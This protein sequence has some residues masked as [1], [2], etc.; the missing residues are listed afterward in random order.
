MIRAIQAGHKSIYK[1]NVV[2]IH[3]ES[4]FRKGVHTEWQEE[5]FMRL[6]NKYKN[7]SF[8]NIAPTMMEKTYAS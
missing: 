5:S 1:P 8:I 4:A 3:H 2:A 6:A 7:T